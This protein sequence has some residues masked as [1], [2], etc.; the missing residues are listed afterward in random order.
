MTDVTALLAALVGLHLEMAREVDWGYGC[1]GNCA[2]R[3][4][5]RSTVTLRVAA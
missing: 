5:G 4:T 2:I 3:N 1:G